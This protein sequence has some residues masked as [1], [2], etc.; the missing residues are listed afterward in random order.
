MQNRKKKKELFCLFIFYFLNYRLVVLWRLL[1][2][3]VVWYQM[4]LSGKAYKNAEEESVV[5]LLLS[6]I[7]ATLQS[8]GVALEQ[9]LKIN[10][11]AG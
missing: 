11:V 8:S 10:S 1:Y 7:Q 9:H 4:Q 2:K 5:S 3:K 6:H